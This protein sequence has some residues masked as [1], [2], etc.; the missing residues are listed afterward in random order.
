MIRVFL[1]GLRECAG[2]VGMTYDDDPNSPRSRA[3][4]TGRTFGRWLARGRYGR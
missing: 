1:L 3:Y 4:D 2:E